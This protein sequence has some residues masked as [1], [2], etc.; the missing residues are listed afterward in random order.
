M[1]ASHVRSNLPYGSPEWYDDIEM[2]STEYLAYLL[3]QDRKAK[4]PPT[5]P[6]AQPAQQEEKKGR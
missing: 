6:E 2:K 1:N 5:E 4:A 3:A